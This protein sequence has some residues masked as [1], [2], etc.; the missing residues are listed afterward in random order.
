MEGS[1]PAGVLLLDKP[2]GPT[3][4]D[5]VGRAR[6][7]LGLRRVGHT[8]TLDPFATGLLLLCAGA[9]TRLVRFLQPLPKRYDATIRLGEETE[10]LD[11][12]G[13]VTRS[14]DAWRSVGREEV[15]RALAGLTGRISQVP[16]RYSAKRIDGDRAYRAARA[17]EAVELE[18]REVVVHELELSGFDLPEVRVETTVSSGTYV[19]A[20]A[21]DLGR[22][23]GCGAHLREL[24]RTAVGPFP[25]SEALPADRLTAE[26]WDEA[27]AAARGAWKPP[28]AALPWLPRRV[29]REEE[30]ERVRHGARVE[31]GDLETPASPPEDAPGTDEQ[32]AEPVVLVHA[33]RLLAVAEMLDDELQPRVVLDAA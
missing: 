2:A 22:D 6:R 30:A 33:D 27:E 3:S 7:A 25:V 14:S 23:L 20:L 26:A 24:R 29:L 13:E 17:G 31:V 15:E 10:T 8:G 18:P 16:P 4:H 1:E 19:R 9:A 12:E 32:G 21:R 28:L 5:M 11:P